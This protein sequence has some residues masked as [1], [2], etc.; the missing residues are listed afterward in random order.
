MELFPKSFLPESVILV[1]VAMGI[2][3]VTIFTIYVTNPANN[4]NFSTK[5]SDYQQLEL[6]Q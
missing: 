4:Q 1:F 5:A 2:A 3:I 6:L